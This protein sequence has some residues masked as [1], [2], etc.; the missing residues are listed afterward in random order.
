[1]PYLL[2]GVRS[3][4]EEDADT[5]PSRAHTQA[6]LHCGAVAKIPMKGQTDLNQAVTQP[7]CP[8]GEQEAAHHPEIDCPQA[9]GQRA[10]SFENNGEEASLEWKGCPS[11]PDFFVSRVMAAGRA[12]SEPYLCPCVPGATEFGQCT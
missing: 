9:G 1:M 4:P 11:A 5:E 10:G 2:C 12:H 3:R 8:K 6:W 7:S